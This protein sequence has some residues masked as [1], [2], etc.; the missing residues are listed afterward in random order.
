M[1]QVKKYIKDTNIHKE[2]LNNEYRVIF[3]EI[4]VYFRTSALPEE[5][6]EVTI[7][8]ILSSF[9]EAQE[10]GKAIEQVIG[11][12]Y[13]DFCESIIAEFKSTP[14]DRKRIIL[15]NISM[16]FLIITSIITVNYIIDSVRYFIKSRSMTFN[17]AVSLDTIIQVLMG[18]VAVYVMFRYVR[19][20]GVTKTTRKAK[21][22][23]YGT[24]YLASLIYILIFVGL[25]YFKIDKIV[26]FSV[27]IY[28]II[29]L[30]CL[31]I[32]IFDYFANK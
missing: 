28:I 6:I 11:E 24:L 8:D 7:Q 15:S 22:K 9:L 19:G 20:S 4:M 14:K 12:S 30:L 1:G 31:I 29:P 10:A 13:K 5:E 23:E 32:K 2:K 27:E 3:D 18:I 26:F 16:L 17:Y 21:L 25:E